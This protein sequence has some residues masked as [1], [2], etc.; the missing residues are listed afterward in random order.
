[1]YILRTGDRGVNE[2]P[3]DVQSDG[4]FELKIGINQIQRPETQQRAHFLSQ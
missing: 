2:M 3:L 4:R 1:M